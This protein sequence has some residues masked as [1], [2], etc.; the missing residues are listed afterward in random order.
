M[1]GVIAPVFVVAFGLVVGSFLNVCI[2]RLPRRES[3]A[4]RL[5][6]HVVR[7][8]AQLHENSRFF[9][10][11]LRTLPHVRV[12]NLDPVLDRRG[13]PARCFSP[14]SRVRPHAAAAR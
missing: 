1:T 12:A 7:P 10:L 8:R 13:R 3:V 5:A 6:L 14:R 2:Y 9:W 4:C 11:V